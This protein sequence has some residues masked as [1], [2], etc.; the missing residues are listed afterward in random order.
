MSARCHCQ[1]TVVNGDEDITTV[2]VFV[3]MLVAWGRIHT[4]MSNQAAA[5]TPPWV[6]RTSLA[7]RL[8]VVT[9][10]FMSTSSRT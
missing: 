9:T 6:H 4:G 1:L 7:A 10:V 3:P 5:S 2:M 8:A